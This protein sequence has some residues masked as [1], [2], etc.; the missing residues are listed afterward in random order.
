[1]ASSQVAGYTVSKVISIAITFYG[2]FIYIYLSFHIKTTPLN[3]SVDEAIQNSKKSSSFLLHMMVMIDPQQIKSNETAKVIY[4]SLV[5]RVL[6][7]I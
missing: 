1:M 5:E 2:I 4:S 7:C 6:K 3:L